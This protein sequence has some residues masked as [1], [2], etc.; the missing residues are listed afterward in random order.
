MLHEATKDKVEY[1][2][3]DSITALRQDE[4]GVQVEFERG[5]FRT[6]DVVIGADGLHSAVRRLAFGPEQQFSSHLGQY[7]AIFPMANF[8]GLDNWQVWF[9]DEASGA[10]GGVYPVRDNTE[11]RV[12]LGFMSEPVT[13][14]YRDTEQQ[15]RLM[16]ERLAGLGWE[17][18]KLL[19]GMAEAPDFYFDAMSQIHMDR[20]TTGRVALVGDAGHCASV[21]SGQ[22]TSLALVGAYVLAEELGRTGIDHTAAF[23][24]YER[25]VRPFVALNQALATENPDGPAPEESLNR[26]KNGIS[27]DADA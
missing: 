2:F 19:S 3:G 11:L 10:G 25:R 7:L 24:A 12:T 9:R 23:A 5:G 6:F 1:V 14:D 8:L 18:P 26:A 4:R 17:V 27:L 13:Y 15:K 16:A 22:G 21:L 20:W